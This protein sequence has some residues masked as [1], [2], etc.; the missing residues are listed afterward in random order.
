[1]NPGSSRAGDRY[2]IDQTT[3]AASAKNA[4]TWWTYPSFRQIAY[5]AQQETSTNSVANASNG[6]AAR[7]SRATRT[8]TVKSS[9]GA[10]STER[11]LISSNPRRR[12]AAASGADR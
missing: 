10:A 11:A 2:L 1:M 7:G 9:N 4:A 5:A 12:C 3:C 6:D 8:G